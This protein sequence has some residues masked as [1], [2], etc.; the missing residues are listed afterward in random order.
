MYSPALSTLL[1]GVMNT[2]C[3]S[4]IMDCIQFN[5]AAQS[6]PQERLDD[7]DI[8]N[9]DHQTQ[10]LFFDPGITLPQCS[11][12]PPE[13]FSA[14]LDEF[15]SASVNLLWWL[16]K[17]C[18]TRG[19]SSCASFMKRTQVPRRSWLNGLL[20]IPTREIKFGCGSSTCSTYLSG[21]AIQT[22]KAAVTQGPKFN[23][24]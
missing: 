19:Y 8:V 4:D 21:V 13:K 17:F 6:R 10:V 2:R 11:G 24:T 9:S 12:T 20:F 18:K 1:L 5:I 23:R 3:C 14:M 16:N 15:S 7:K 22:R